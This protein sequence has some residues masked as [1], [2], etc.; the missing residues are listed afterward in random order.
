MKLKI[1]SI[2]YLLVIDDGLKREG[3]IGQCAYMEQEIRLC[4][5]ISG[6]KREAT[7]WHEILHAIFNQIGEEQNEAL[8][9]RLSYQIHGVLKE[10]ASF[11]LCEHLLHVK[12]K[13]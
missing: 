5:S 10:N 4:P 9:D 12:D 3:S 8:I 6:D 7:F 13:A 2:D 1:G 11:Y